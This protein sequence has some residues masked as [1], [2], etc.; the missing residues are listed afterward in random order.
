MSAFTIVVLLGVMAAGYYATLTPVTVIVDGQARTIKTNQRSVEN[1]LRE[2]GVKIEA[3]DIV[4]PAL[5]AAL[6]DDQSTIIVQHAR[7]VT[8]QVDGQTQEFR[9]QTSLLPEI[10]QEA[11]INL[12]DFDRVIVNGQIVDRTQHQSFAIP[13]DPRDR[14]PIDI[15]IQRAVPVTLELS[16]GSEHKLQTPARTVGEALND[17]GVQ[18]YLA[19]RITPTLAS[20]IAPGMMITVEQSVPINIDVDGRTIRTRTLRNQ[21]GEV[22]NDLGVALVGQ[23]YTQPTIDAAVQQ[24]STVTVVRVREEVLVEQEAIPYETVK[25]ADSQ[26]ELDTSS[27]TD[28]ENGIQQKR[29]VIRYENGQEV[30]RNTDPDFVVLKSPVNKE[31]R[32]GTNIVIHTLD[33]PNGPIEYW[34]KIRAYATSYSAATSGTPRTAKWYGITATG[35][36][37][38]KGIIAVD[39]SVI[40][41]GTKVYVPNYGVGLAAD[42][43]GGVR[44]KWLDLGYDDDNLQGW[45]WWV[46]A[47]LLTPVPANVNYELPNWPQYRDRGN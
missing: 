14:S 38:R 47:Y 28:G 36:P 12:R 16:Q 11:G 8:V 45:W 20:P 5:T 19:D 37:M 15:T 22:L 39:P 4:G 35:L 33:T 40:G 43:G 7:P 13:R 17:A 24:D 42:T 41:L 29:T 18:L 3:D 9:S 27:V 6:T 30:A 23:D 21:V 34:R 25:I 44:G 31:Y 46:D 32:Y 1:I 26:M 2:A 10:L